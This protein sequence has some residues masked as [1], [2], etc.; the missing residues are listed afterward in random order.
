MSTADDRWAVILTGGGLPDENIPEP[1]RNDIDLALDRAGDGPCDP[2]LARSIAAEAFRIGYRQ[3]AMLH[4][5]MSVFAVP[6]GQEQ[7][8]AFAAWLT[9]EIDP[10][11]ARRLADPLDELLRSAQPRNEGTYWT[12]GE[13]P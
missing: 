7:A 1:H 5:V 3:A 10:A 9:R 12:V 2:G 6:G 8:E 13:A 4:R 11:Y